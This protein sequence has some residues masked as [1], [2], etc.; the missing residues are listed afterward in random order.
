MKHGQG[1]YKWINGDK[2][3]GAY[4]E[5]ERNGEG[6]FTWEDGHKYKGEWKNN[7]KC[8]KG[9]LFDTKGKL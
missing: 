7:V 9:E 5:N 2:Y 6:E 4:E 3:T 1:V 8:G